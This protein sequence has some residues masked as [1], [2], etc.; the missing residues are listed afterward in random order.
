M[1]IAVTVV[2]ILIR[3][4]WL[5]LLVLGIVFW[6]GRGQELVPAHQA[7][8]VVFVLLLWALAYLGLRSGAAT[9]LIVATFVWGL[10]VLTLG[11]AQTQLLTGS[12]HWTIQVLHLLVGIAAIGLAESLAARIKSRLS[13]ADRTNQAL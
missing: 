10:I 2:Q 7:V 5:I 3:L 9:G 13:A 12:S 6:T 8:G 4:T 1:K 11:L